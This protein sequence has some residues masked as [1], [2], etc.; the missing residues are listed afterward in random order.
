MSK[1]NV[2]DDMNS[3]PEVCKKHDTTMYWDGNWNCSECQREDMVY[4]IIHQFHGFELCMS[5]QNNNDGYCIILK[6]QMPIEMCGRRYKCKYYKEWI[7][8]FDEVY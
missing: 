7:P 3:M 5:C 4:E 2:I 6:P 1:W 8:C